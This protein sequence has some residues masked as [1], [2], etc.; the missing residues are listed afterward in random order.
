MP[1]VS[2]ASRHR[3]GLTGVLLRAHWIGAASAPG[4]WPEGLQA[5]LRLKNTQG[6]QVSEDISKVKSW[7][8]RDKFHVQTKELDCLA[9]S[10]MD[11]R[12][13]SDPAVCSQGWLCPSRGSRQSLVTLQSVTRR[14]KGG[15]HPGV[16]LRRLHPRTAPQPGVMPTAPT[17]LNWEPALHGLPQV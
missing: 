12:E 13:R 6:W 9:R 10:F 17:R 2:G 4:G 14:G 1:L 5:S 3:T 16:L 15:E 11:L 8:L 7:S